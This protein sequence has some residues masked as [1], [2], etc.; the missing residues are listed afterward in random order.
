MF[1]PCVQTNGEAGGGVEGGDG[2][3][4]GGDGG[5]AG[6]YTTTVSVPNATAEMIAAMIIKS[7]IM[8]TH[9]THVW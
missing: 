1:T 6:L 4:E 7:T 9:Q 2:G 5:N 3:V 8:L